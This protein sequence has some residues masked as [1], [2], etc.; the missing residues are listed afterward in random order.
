V[1]SRPGE[2]DAIKLDEQHNTVVCPVPHD[3]GFMQI[4]RDG[5]RIVQTL[6]AR[7][8]E[9]PDSADTPNPLHRE[10]ARI[11]AERRDFPITDVVEATRKFAQPELLTTTI[12]MVPNVPFGTTAAAATSTVITPI[13]RTVTSV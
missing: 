9:M 10:V 8:F 7:N 4:F 13:A 5:W 3:G 1:P 6:C 11:F 2:S 12:E